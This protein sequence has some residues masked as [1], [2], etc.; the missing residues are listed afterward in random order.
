MNEIEKLE[1]RRMEI[2]K[3]I[4]SIRAMRK[5][6][7]TEQYLKVAHKGKREPALRGPYFLYTRKEKGKTVGRRL[8]R[9][10]AD[11]FR[12]QVEAFHRFQAL[13]KEY[14][15]ISE[16]MADLAEASIW[17]KKRPRSPSNKTMR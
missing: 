15:E 3:D 5:G 7:V 14:A 9:E 17:E 2:I 10:E 6:S 16:R 13:A 4:S 8:S 11:P 1:K 12:Q